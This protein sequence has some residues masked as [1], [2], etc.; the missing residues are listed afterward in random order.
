VNSASSPLLSVILPCHNRADLLPRLLQAYE[1]QE[2]V[3]PF[4][5]VAVDDGSTDDTTKILS[6]W[7][8]S[9]F[10]LVTERQPHRGPA[11][12]R[13]RALEKARGRVLL[14][15]G[16][17]I[18]PQQ[19]MLA[20]HLQIHERLGNEELAVLGLTTWPQGKKV[21]A[22]MKHIDGVGGEQFAYH[23]IRDGMLLDFRFFYTSNVS[24]GRR[25][26]QAM[27]YWFDTEFPGAAYEDIEFAY[28]L[29]GEKR[30][31]HYSSEPRAEH[32]HFYDARTFIER[33]FKCGQA[34]AFLVNK[35]PCLTHRLGTRALRRLWWKSLWGLRGGR[36][37][38]LFWKTLDDAESSATNFV[39]LF[40]DHE[41]DDLANVRKTL[42]Q[43]FYIKG[44][45]DQVL[46][47]KARSQ[48][49]A[50][51]MTHRVLKSIQKWM[52][53]QS[54]HLPLNQILADEALRGFLRLN[55]R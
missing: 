18:V 44:L 28:R 12:A 46:E 53:R 19:K 34:A 7:R 6:S 31:V 13:N 22:T 50:Y 47:D 10:M 32:H 30:R 43:H 54:G 25:Q 45:V 15:T 16:D 17:D 35:W 1:T 21:T 41:G 4:E 14:F 48:L 27:D 39:L 51:T 9:K 23:Y 5:I 33:Q 42:F 55:V 26:I 52:R 49:L 38:G 11:A 36:K 2:D 3:G 20:N 8:S 24:I 29:F 40:D 37:L